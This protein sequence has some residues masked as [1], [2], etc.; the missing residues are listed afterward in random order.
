LRNVKGVAVTGNTFFGGSLG[1]DE[2][3]KRP[4]SPRYGMILQNL[5]GCV[6]ANNSLYH[7]AL[8]KVILDRGGHENSV[9]RDNPGSLRGPG[10]DPR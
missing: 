9:I 1:S 7:A 5:A 4:P 10:F 8:E 2:A 6:V 3:K